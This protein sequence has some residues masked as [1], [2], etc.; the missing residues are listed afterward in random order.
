MF[1]LVPAIVWLP[2]DW[3]I[4][5]IVAWEPRDEWD[6]FRLSQQLGAAA[7]AVVGTFATAVVMAATI[8]LGRGASIDLATVLRRGSKLWARM[9]AV[10]LA[11]TL[12]VAIGLLL[13][14]VPGLVLMVRYALAQ[15]AAAF[16]RLRPKAALQTSARCVRGAPVSVVLWGVGATLL[17]LPTALA[18][19]LLLPGAAGSWLV[20]AAFAPSNVFFFSFMTIGLALLYADRRDAER[21][22]SPVGLDPVSPGLPREPS[23]G[24]RGVIVAAAFAVAA[25][26][27]ALAVFEWVPT[28][29]VAAGEEAWERDQLA[30]ALGHYERA[31]YWSPEYAYAHYRIGW[32]H[33]ALDHHRAALAAYDKALELEPG[34]LSYHLDRARLLVAMDRPHALDEALRR[35]AARPGPEEDDVEAMTTTLAED[36]LAR[37]RLHMREG[38][39]GD[40]GPL[41]RKGESLAARDGRGDELDAALAQAALDRVRVY[42]ALGGLREARV[43]FT[44]VRGLA[45]VDPASLE[46]LEA[47]IAEAHL[48]L[49]AQRIREGRLPEARKALDDA[50][51]QAIVSQGAVHE[52]EAVL[53]RALVEE[54]EKERRALDR[55]EGRDASPASE[56]R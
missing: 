49:V 21:L 17:Y 42:L 12:R 45:R 9:T 5:E 31:V 43:A 52:L 39:P 10:L 53:A 32:C 23:S 24:W 22:L 35:A 18:P 30:E 47:A 48:E 3:L 15:P 33:R 36:L 6:A 38:R 14:L 50:R 7:S 2:V 46:D 19:A 44:E 40:A 34:E 8:D 56:T 11:V 4:E 55:L 25:P 41:L 1:L 28:A 51:D 54:I 26:T 16:E 29:A 37:A 27:G 20:A 13:L